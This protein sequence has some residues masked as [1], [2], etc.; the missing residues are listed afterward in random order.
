[1]MPFSMPEK[2]KLGHYPLADKIVLLG[3]ERDD[4]LNAL[5]GLESAQERVV[6]VLRKIRDAG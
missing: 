3:S 5:A 6:S 4:L 1:M 2:F